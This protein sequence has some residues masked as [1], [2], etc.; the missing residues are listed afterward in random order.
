MARLKA[1]ERKLRRWFTV[2][3]LRPSASFAS[4]N[5]RMS[6]GRAAWSVSAARRDESRWMRTLLSMEAPD[7]S[8]WA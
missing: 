1:R 4:R 3:A 8:R 6:V 7:A 2:W 5:A